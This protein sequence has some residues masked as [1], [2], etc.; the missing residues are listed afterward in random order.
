[1]EI[2]CGELLPALDVGGGPHCE[3]LPVPTEADRVGRA[4]V[5][6]DAGDWEQA[7]YVHILRCVLPDDICVCVNDTW[8]KMNKYGTVQELR[9]TFSHI[10]FINIDF[11]LVWFVSLCVDL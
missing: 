9:S 3:L 8:G 11:S 6:D 5:V 1:M 10:K 2:V 4:G 7:L